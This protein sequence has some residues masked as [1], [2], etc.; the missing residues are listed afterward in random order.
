MGKFDGVLFCTDLDG[1]LLRG[2]KTVSAENRA[3]IDYFKSE[4]G[5]FTFITG[6]LPFTAEDI[7]RA[8]Q[9]NAPFGCING[10]AVYDPAT[11]TYLWKQ[12]LPR[13]ALELVEYVDNNIEDF[14]VQ[15]NLF[16]KAYF[17]RENSA[18]ATFRKLTGAPNIVVDYKDVKEPIAKV[19]F[20]DE[21]EGGIDRVLSLLRSHPRADEFAFVSSEPTLGEILP[22]GIHKGVALQKMVECIGVVPEKT[23]AIGDY[24]NDIGM[25]KTAGLGIAV[26]NALPEVKAVADHVTV[27]NEEHA[28]ARVVRDLDSGTLQL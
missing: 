6:R 19:V 5:L 24:Y 10:G 13:A 8:V 18:M 22:K 27:G 28:I 12:E 9:P 4:G 11:K 26:G 2:D 7:V 20:G 16:D 23:I 15:I 3:A 21:R 14:G 25:L 1:T 17:S